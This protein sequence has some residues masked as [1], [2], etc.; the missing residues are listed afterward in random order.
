MLQRFPATYFELAQSGTGSAHAP[1]ARC[2]PPPP[3]HFL[4]NRFCSLGLF[5]AGLSP[6]PSPAE[7]EQKTHLPPTQGKRVARGR[8][9]PGPAWDPP[10][11]KV[12]SCK[13]RARTRF[14]NAKITTD[15]AAF[16]SFEVSGTDDPGRKSSCSGR[17]AQLFAVVKHLVCNTQEPV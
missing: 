13:R 1:G 16:F 12:A 4:S 6:R 8:V 3:L 17:R 15:Q 9:V 14:F 7:G 10:R 2:A 5:Q 11:N